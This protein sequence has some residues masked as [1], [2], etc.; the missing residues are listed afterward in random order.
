MKNCN[1]SVPNVRCLETRRRE[2]IDPLFAWELAVFEE[3]TKKNR[4]EV[5]HSLAYCKYI[6]EIDSLV[7]RENDY[8][9]SHP[10]ICKLGLDKGQGF[11]KLTAQYSTPSIV[12]TS[13]I[14]TLANPNTSFFKSEHPKYN[15][16]RLYALNKRL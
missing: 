2:I 12:R 13:P 14:R 4:S 15:F 6:V 8:D 9:S 10:L 16:I 1:I 7:K 3:G 11:L 5:E